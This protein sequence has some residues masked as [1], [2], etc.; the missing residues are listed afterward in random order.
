ME[1]IPLTAKG[2]AKLDAE[3]KKLKSV[4]RPQVIAAITAAIDPHALA[5]RSGELPDHGG[6]DGLLARTFQHGLAAFGI[7]FGLVPNGFEAG[8]TLLQRRVVQIGDARLD[9]VIE[10]LEAQVGLSGALIQ[11]RDVFAATLG[12]L[13]A[14]VER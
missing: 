8:D 7:S 1:K 12:A 10:P 5:G 9:G 4:E 3:L 14:V 13:L 6:G 11:F 2:F